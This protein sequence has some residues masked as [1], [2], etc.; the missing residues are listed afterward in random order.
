MEFEW[1]PLKA[2]SNEKKHDVSFQEALS[3]FQDPLSLSIH[4]PVHS[5][6]ED[7]FVL[8]GMT[9][10]NRLMVVVYTTRGESIRIISARSATQKERRDYESTPK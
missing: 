3:A 1:D 4:D 2:I 8:V 10:K 6:E 7:R 5:E 9:E